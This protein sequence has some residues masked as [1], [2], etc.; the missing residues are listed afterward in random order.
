MAGLLDSLEIANSGLRAAQVGLDLTG[1]NLA[2]VAN[3]AYARRRVMLE[4]RRVAEGLSGGV[5]VRSIEGVRDRL[6]DAQI[7]REEAVTAHLEARQRTLQLAQ[8]FLGQ[9]I[10]QQSSAGNPAS[11]ALGTGQYNLAFGLSQFFAAA[12]R[13]AINPNSAA[14]R[15]ILAQNGSQLA[16]RFRQV[17]LRLRQIA[18]D[19]DRDITDEVGKANE[20]LGQISG[21]ARELTQALNLRPASVP[22]LQDQLQGRLEE[23]GQM[24][25]FEAGL[26]ENNQLQLS[27]GG[28]SLISSNRLVGALEVS[29]TPGALQVEVVNQN[30]DRAALTTGRIQGWIE[31]RD[32]AVASLIGQND[33]LAKTLIS[34][35]NRLHSGGV[36]LD[37]LGGRDFFLGTGASDLQV[38]PELLANGRKIQ[39]SATG[40]PGDNG[41]AVALGRLGETALDDLSGLT[42]SSFYNQSV[43]G[44]GQQLSSTN[45]QLQDQEVIAGLLRNQRQS[46]SGVNIDEEM[47]NL[48]MLQRAFQASAR[49][50]STVDTLMETVIN[51]G[52]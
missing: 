45:S 20:L 1:N 37:G 14:D 22:A 36:G 13:A 16:D 3:P 35:V 15:Q 28:V 42:F 52:R 41:I 17:D 51:L 21:V 6:L 24:L 23:L 33:L 31:A 30:G 44:F 46:I 38:N 19:L 27:V 34:E 11:A 47:S 5:N 29:G 32:G 49:M 8:G 7:I 26:D 9:T 40:A 18:T 50:V 39:L 48:L 12:Q 10:D 43:A 25:A 2:N 4:A